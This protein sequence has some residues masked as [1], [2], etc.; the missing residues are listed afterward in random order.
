MSDQVLMMK[1]I[2]VFFSC[3]LSSEDFYYST[4]YIL[5]TARYS[6]LMWPPYEKFQVVQG[7]SNIKT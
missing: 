2:K 6:I 3:F 7:N 5:K 1:I 4:C